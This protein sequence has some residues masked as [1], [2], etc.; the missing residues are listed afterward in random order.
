MGTFGIGVGV[1][2][3][4]GKPKFFKG[5]TEEGKFDLIPF[6]LALTAMSETYHTLQNRFMVAHEL[7]HLTENLSSHSDS[8]WREARADFLAYAITGQTEIVLPE[9]VYLEKIREDGTQYREFSTHPRSFTDPSVRSVNKALPA[10]SSFHFNSQII[11]SALYE[12]SQKIGVSR[13]VEFVQWMDEME[14]PNT[15]RDP[16]GEGGNLQQVKAE[17]QKNIMR[18][19]QYLRQWIKES[20][21]TASE[22]KSVEE[23][24]DVRGL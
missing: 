23:I 19:G 22:K 4:S 5:L 11:S 17:I 2:G 21:L 18:V 9:G 15:I 10:I 3:I 1:P 24:L 7:A 16:E 20:N 14:G 8:I 6:I 13:A 12:I